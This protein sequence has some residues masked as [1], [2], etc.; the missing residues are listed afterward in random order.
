MKPRVSTIQS[1]YFTD[2]LPK[3]RLSPMSPGSSHW[4]PPKPTKSGSVL[5]NKQRKSKTLKPLTHFK[6]TKID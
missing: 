1:H 5:L 4:V 2:D 3:K 6:S